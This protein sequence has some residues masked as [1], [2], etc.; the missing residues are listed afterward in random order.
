MIPTIP[1]VSTLYV[2]R[3][4]WS[5]SSGNARFTALSWLLPGCDPPALA[6]DQVRPDD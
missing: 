5:N 3:I 1:R 6:P 2:F 4:A